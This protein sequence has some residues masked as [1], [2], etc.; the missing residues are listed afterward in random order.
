MRFDAWRAEKGVGVAGQR[1][2]L[3]HYTTRNGLG[4]ITM[5]QTLRPSLKATNARDVRHGEGQYLSDIVPGSKSAGQ[6][7]YAF[8][9]DPRGWRRFTHYVEI[10]VTWLTVV[11]GMPGV[12][13]IPNTD[14]L[15]LT[16]RIVSSG[17]V[18]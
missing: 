11:E 1:R 2:T 10:N 6:L 9:N 13:V 15:D 5:S 4:E 14:N 17:P 16:G 12:F 7:A 3:Y 8:L 18:S